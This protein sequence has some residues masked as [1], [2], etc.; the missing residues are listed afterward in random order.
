MKKLLALLLSVMMIMSVMVFVPVAAEDGTPTKIEAVAPSGTG[1]EDD[2]YIIKEAGNLAWIQT[3]I[4][5]GDAYADRDVPA[6][7]A[8]SY[9]EQVCD[10]DLGGNYLYGIGNYYAHE[11]ATKNDVTYDV[12]ERMAAF[13]GT[14]NGN[15]YSIKN[16]YIN[17]ENTGH[18]DNINWSNGL[19]G[20]IYGATIKN[21]VMDNVTVSG[22]TIVGGIVGRAASP[23]CR[24]NTGNNIN[25]EPNAYSTQQMINV[26]ENC[27]MKSTCKVTSTATAQ[28]TA[29]DAAFRVGGMVGFAT[30]TTIRNCVNEAEVSVHG[31]ISMA[32]G[33]VGAGGFGLVIENCANK[34]DIKVNASSIVAKAESAYG[35]ILGF[36][37]PYTTG[38]TASVLK[39]T[40]RICNCYN[41]GGFVLTGAA[42]AA[43]YWGGIL[44]GANSPAYLTSASDKDNLIENCY[45][46]YALK[47]ATS[48]ASGTG[49]MRVAGLIGSTWN[50]GGS[51]TATVYLE[52]SS[53]VAVDRVVYWTGSNEYNARG[54]SNAAGLKEVT[55]TNVTTKTADEIKVFTDAIDKKI[56]NAQEIVTAYGVQTGT[57]KETVEGVEVEKKVARLVSNIDSKNYTAV[58]YEAE[59]YIGDATTP[60]KADPKTTTTAYNVVKGYDAQGNVI[61]YTTETCGGAYLVA[62]NIDLSGF[63]ADVTV[64]F[65][66]TSFVIDM[67][68]NRIDGAKVEVS[69][70]NG[71][72]VEGTAPAYIAD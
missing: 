71:A 70:L 37:T 17:E 7:F 48:Y 44:G 63:E 34:G 1:T 31:G 60:L 24:V 15:G 3:K 32:G 18:G 65:V 46:L 19:F 49:N 39:G 27:V 4:V 67:D 51:N 55:P 72:I 57:I 20:V 6:S 62:M 13:G 47:A 50:N 42:K 56:A 28:A 59:C 66:I 64:R 25:G 69:F 10:I 16:G 38:S 68:G 26:I 12:T 5:K 30:G 22:K 21:V 33:L 11:T 35:G 41:S 61:D 53:S 8:D 43:T 9:F 52:N 58:G 23:F 14:Y 2:P 40:V 29:Y 36:I 54:N 45:N